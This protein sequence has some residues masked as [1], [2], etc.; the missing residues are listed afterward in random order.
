[1]ELQGIKISF[2]MAFLT[3]ADSV[4]VFGFSVVGAW[5]ASGLHAL[6]P[7]LFLVHSL[8]AFAVLVDAAL[9]LLMR[10]LVRR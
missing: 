10:L 3:V 7:Q 5:Y 4:A 2:V 1:M 9:W 8:M 6:L